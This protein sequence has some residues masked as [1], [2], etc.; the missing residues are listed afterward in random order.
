MI[1]VTK[2]FFPERAEYQKYLDQIWDNKWVTNNGPMVKELESS[3]GR[4]LKTTK[5]K[6]VSNGTLAL[7]IAIKA[8]GLKGKII[9]TPFSYVATTSSIV[10]EG[11]EPVF[12]DIDSDTLNICP[13]S[14]EALMDDNVVG[15][16]ATHCFGNACDIDRIDQ[17]SR[18]HN[19]PVIYDAAHCFGTLYKGE[20][21]FNFGD[22][23]ICSL[24]AT[25]LMHSVE[26]GL[27]FSKD[28]QMDDKISYLRN[29]GHDGYE[30]FQG[31]GVNGKNS[32]FHAAMGLCVLHHFSS[33]SKK[34]IEQCEIYD[35]L[36]LELNVNRP[37]VS[38][39]CEP[40]RSYYPIIF[41][42]EELCERAKYSLE[43]Q[44]IMARRYFYPPLNTLSYVKEQSTPVASDIS[45][46][47]LCLPLYH[48]LE[49]TQQKM[50]C[51]ILLND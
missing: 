47:I 44:G 42:S 14:I 43:E 17:I 23:S 38:V 11:C 18:Q 22:L 12:A 51:K 31:L 3:I 29:F 2:P 25:K 50:I 24:H 41:E 45:S 49:Y 10:W 15:I 6:L 26:G 40:N 39:D 48:D 9:T 34:R 19:I 36:L 13:K 7:Q 35:E 20:S 16:V 30:H 21:I 33:L 28:L 1:L 37:T 4:N 46:R 5:P 8:L 32:E 27:I